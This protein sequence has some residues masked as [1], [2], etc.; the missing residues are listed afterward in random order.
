MLNYANMFV[1]VLNE[2][3]IIKYTNNSL[4]KTL[5]FLTYKDIIGRCWIDFLIEDEI[6]TVK[7][8]HKKIADGEE[9]WT[10][11]KEFRNHIKPMMGEPIMVHWFN[12]HINSEYNWSFSFGLRKDR[13]PIMVTMDSIRDYYK[14]IIE[15]DRT[16]IESMKDTIINDEDKKT[17][18][19]TLNM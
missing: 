5:G 2:E 9:D 16:M 7:I 8:V 11:Y 18:Q 10:K 13:N 3:M 17:C 12:S 6:K 14:D 15:Y 4:A 1:L 19:P